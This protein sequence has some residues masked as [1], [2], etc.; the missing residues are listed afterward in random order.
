M[1][2]PADNLTRSSKFNMVWS[3]PAR[4]ATYLH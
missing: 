2:F 1:L 4:W 3:D